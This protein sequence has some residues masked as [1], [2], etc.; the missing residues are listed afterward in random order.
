MGKGAWYPFVKKKFLTI[1]HHSLTNG[2]FRQEE[3][4]KADKPAENTFGQRYATIR[5]LNTYLYPPL[6]IFGH[7]HA[8]AQ[9]S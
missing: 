5:Q 2:I 3:Q 6:S 7:G 9:T 4:A 1:G 8:H